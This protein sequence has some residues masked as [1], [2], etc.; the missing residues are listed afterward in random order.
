MIVAKLHDQSAVTEEV[1]HRI[2]P[3]ELSI[4][5]P[6]YFARSF[7]SSEKFSLWCKH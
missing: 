2:A 3:E 7:E 4:M 5:E 6:I 1:V